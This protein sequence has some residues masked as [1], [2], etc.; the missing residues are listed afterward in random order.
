VYLNVEG[1]REGPGRQGLGVTKNLY[2]R[3]KDW[4]TKKAYALTKKTKNQLFDNEEG[5]HEGRYKTNLM[6][7]GRGPN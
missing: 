2:P 4:R 7:H 5:C 3:K 6:K 1:T